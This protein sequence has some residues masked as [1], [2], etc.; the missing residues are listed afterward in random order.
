MDGQAG[1]DGAE[2]PL[3]WC[4][5]GPC[6]AADPLVTAVLLP[7][8]LSF[9]VMGSNAIAGNEMQDQSISLAVPWHGAERGAGLGTSH[10]MA[11]CFERL[12]KSMLFLLEVQGETGD[13]INFGM[14]E[15]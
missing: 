8:T 4:K 2:K 1:I 7:V 5:L 6:D 12:Q 14:N 11:A 15:A 9:P 3:V 10:L 13:Q